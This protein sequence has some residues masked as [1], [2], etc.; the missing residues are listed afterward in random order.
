MITDQDRE[1]IIGVT[2]AIKMLRPRCN[3]ELHNTTFVNWHDEDGLPPP[4]WE[5]VIHT[6]EQHKIQWV[7]DTYKRERAAEYPDTIEQLEHLWHTINNGG[8]IDSSSQ[9]FNQIKDIKQKY[10]KVE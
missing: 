7:K 8:V 2:D 1:Y 4:L 10:P 9:W 6:M 5:E 3:Y